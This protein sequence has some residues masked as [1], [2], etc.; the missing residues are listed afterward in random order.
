MSCNKHSQHILVI[1]EDDANRQIAN[2][3]LLDANV[4]TR[5][6]QVLEVAGGWQKAVTTL[7]SD[8]F[9]GLARY[10]T[11]HLVLLIDFDGDRHRHQ[12]ITGQVPAA[13]RDRVFVLGCWS[14]PEALR[15]Q[16]GS[17]ETIGR[18][19]AANCQ[20]PN[21]PVWTNDLLSHNAAELEKMRRIVSPFLFL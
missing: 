6:I 17:Y 11:R 19:L 14:E 20:D 18:R 1:P 15:R 4:D 9:N 3:F 16:L 5:R 8:H 7:T 13:F 21:D 10:P 12:T 2:G